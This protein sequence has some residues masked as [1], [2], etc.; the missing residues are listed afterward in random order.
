MSGKDSF[1]EDERKNIEKTV[2]MIENLTEKT[3]LSKYEVIAFGTLLQNIYTG[4]EGVLRYQL[5][6]TGVRV[7]KDENWHKNLLMKSRESGIISDAQFEIL[8]ELL[9]FRHMHMHGYGFMLD[10]TRLRELAAPVP[11][12]CKGFLKDYNK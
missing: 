11:D 4:I 3:D 8:L 1:L 10:E 2:L 7:Q 12:L 5:Q 9:L 6:N